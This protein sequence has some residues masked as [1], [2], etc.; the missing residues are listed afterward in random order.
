MDSEL[1]PY[2]GLHADRTLTHPEVGPCFAG[3]G[4]YLVEEMLRA[5][6]AGRLRIRSILATPAA[7]EH[8]AA[9]LPAE[10]RLLVVEKA[11]LQALVGFPFQRGLIALAAIPP[12]PDSE[13]LTQIHRLLVLPR[14]DNAENLGAL[15]R[16]AVALGMEGVL[17]GQGPSPFVTRALRVAMGAT[18]R[19]P[20]WH[21][22][23]PMPLLQTWKATGGEVV[24]AALDPKSEDASQWKPSPR[25]ALL[26]GAEDRGLDAHWLSACDRLLRI[27]MH[28]AMDSLNVG[29]AGAILM[30]RLTGAI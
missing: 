30:A 14:L 9:D 28:G 1:L 20:L 19:L 13:V 29:A 26:L 16:S 21:R 7:S 18:W 12:E 4:R 27:S 15:L 17:V 2:Q 22:E 6:R 3:E 24:G 25:T 5:H 8:V 11:E 23:D 10:V